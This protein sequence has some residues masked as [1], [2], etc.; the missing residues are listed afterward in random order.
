MAVAKRASVDK[1]H[2]MGANGTLVVEHIPAKGRQLFKHSL[3][4]LCNRVRSHATRG[5]RGLAC[6]IGSELDKSHANHYG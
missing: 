5:C 4:R 6:E 3:E 1:N 2:D